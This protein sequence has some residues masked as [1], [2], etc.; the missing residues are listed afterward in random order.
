M[1]LTYSDARLALSEYLTKLNSDAIVEVTEGEQ[2]KQEKFFIHKPFS[3]STGLRNVISIRNSSQAAIDGA[4]GEEKC[5][6]NAVTNW[7]TAL[8]NVGASISKCTI[9]TTTQMETGAENFHEYVQQQSAMSFEVQNLILNVFV[10][11]SA[12]RN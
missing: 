10:E 1:M 2:L 5:V 11:V 8:T 6:R 7:E 4:S 3:I 12:E 9:E